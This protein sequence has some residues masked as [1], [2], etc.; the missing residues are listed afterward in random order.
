M[1]AGPARISSRARAR[2]AHRPAAPPAVPVGVSLPVERKINDYREFTGQTE[3]VES[4]E[5]RARVT[6]YLNK[7][8]FR[9]GAEVKKGD[10]LCKNDKRQGNNY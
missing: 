2:R 8:C 4:V 1:K 5:I 9:D 7:V 3:A 10:L 6:G